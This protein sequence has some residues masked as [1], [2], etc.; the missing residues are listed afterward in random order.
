MD[1]RYDLA[2]NFIAVYLPAMVTNAAPVAFLSRR[3]C[4][5]LDLG[6]VLPDGRRLL[7]DGKTVEGVLVGLVSGLAVSLLL[8]LSLPEFSSLLLRTGLVSSCGA[9]IGDLAKSFLK[10]RA[11]IERGAPLVPADQLDFYLGAT[12]LVLACDKCAQPLLA[13]FLL[14]LILVPLLH[15][16]TNYAAYKLGLKRVPW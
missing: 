11:G 14:G 8:A 6:L 10:R 5:P 3:R 1:P 7:G 4:T 12:L 2:A 13:S 9:I 16:S 15:L